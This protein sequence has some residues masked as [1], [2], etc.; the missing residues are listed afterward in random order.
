MLCVQ[1]ESKFSPLECSREH[2][3]QLPR[4]LPNHL[5]VSAL[6]HANTAKSVMAVP[7][8]WHPEKIWN[9]AWAFHTIKWLP[10][11]LLFT[12]HSHT[13]ISQLMVHSVRW[14]SVNIPQKIPCFPYVKYFSWKVLH[15]MAYFIWSE[16]ISL[17]PSKQLIFIHFVEGQ[18]SSNNSSLERNN[19]IVLSADCSV[20]YSYEFIEN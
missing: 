18:Q 8:M 2:Q 7:Q 14:R 9:K 17:L 20:A 4:T 15:K 6:D 3:H 5:S 12:T 13:A 16:G 10:T 1:V 19:C 11:V